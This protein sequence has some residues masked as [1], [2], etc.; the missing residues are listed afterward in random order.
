MCFANNVQHL[1]VITHHWGAQIEWPRFQISSRARGCLPVSLPPPLANVGGSSEGMDFCG[2][3]DKKYLMFRGPPSV[4]TDPFPA[5]GHQKSLLFCYLLTHFARQLLNRPPTLPQPPPHLPP[6][7][8]H[9]FAL[10]RQRHCHRGVPPRGS[11][12]PYLIC[13]H[14]SDLGPS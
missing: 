4:L 10:P 6:P 8:V 9:V 5:R 1:A 7:Y 3:V 11:R 12:G 14:Q 13:T 2:D